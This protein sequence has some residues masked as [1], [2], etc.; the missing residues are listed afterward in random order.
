MRLSWGCGVNV[1]GGV[2]VPPGC[3]EAGLWFQPYHLPSQVAGLCPLAA[4]GAAGLPLHPPGP[5]E[6][7][8]VAGDRVSV[9][10]RGSS[11]RAWHSPGRQDLS[12][13]TVLHGGWWSFRAGYT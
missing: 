1:G 8:Q 10:S 11:V 6:A 13:T 12:L 9:G 3:L 2:A 7:E 4:P 5:G